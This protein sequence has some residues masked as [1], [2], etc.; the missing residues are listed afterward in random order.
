MRPTQEQWKSILKGPY[1][2][3]GSELVGP[4]PSCGGE[5]RF[6]VKRDGV[7]GCRKC[8]DW[9]AIVKAAGV[10]D[11]TLTAR[12]IH[13]PDRMYAVYKSQ[14]VTL[15][16]IKA[17]RSWIIN[18]GKKPAAWMHKGRKVTMRA[19]LAESDGGLQVARHG[20]HLQNGTMVLP[21][22]SYHKLSA[23]IAENGMDGCVPALAMSGDEKT[24]WMLDIGVIDVDYKPDKDEDGSGK[25]RRDQTRWSLLR[26]GAMVI[27]SQSGNG[28]H[29][30]LRMDPSQWVQ[31]FSG[32]KINGL[33]FDIFPPGSRQSVTLMV[34]DIPAGLCEGQI[35][36]ATN[37]A[38]VSAIRA[39][40]ELDPS[41][42]TGC[43]RYLTP[44]DD[45]T[46]A[47]IENV[48]TL[49]AVCQIWGLPE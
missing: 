28:F 9:Q 30:L 18:D 39:G 29:A 45:V 5:D 2:M 25:A 14:A 27:P 32:K 10:S 36:M 23:Y 24:P 20:G 46:D 11:V 35:P 44:E 49:C 38:V 13:K 7:F 17:A 3:R 16:D 47:E 33:S 31:K 1:V 21:W 4:C 41:R 48:P 12:T 34:A 26:I 15:A 43:N 6:W 37:K 42:C 40:T 22:G 8:N 19:S